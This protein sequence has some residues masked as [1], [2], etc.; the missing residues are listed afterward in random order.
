MRFKLSLLL[1]LCFLT[2]ITNLS[3]IKAV[4]NKPDL[5]ITNLDLNQDGKLEIEV[6]NLGPGS[7]HSQ[8]TA[9]NPPFLYV[10]RNGKAW[11]GVTLGNFDPKKKLKNVGG[12]VKYVFNNL[13]ISDTELVHVIVD[14]NNSIQEINK[15]NNSFQKRLTLTLPDLTV[16]DIFLNNHDRLAIEIT[17]NGSGAVNKMYWEQS[18]VYLYIYRDGKPWGGISLKICD[19]SYKLY[20]PKG[21]ALYISNS[22]RI[23][24]SEQIQV[25]IDPQNMVRETNELNNTL[26]KLLTRASPDLAYF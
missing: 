1:I 24:H 6:S 21:K 18:P 8:S 3:D 23:N 22:I 2:V 26:Q 15:I 9:K 11:G 4:S 17:N 19:P 5:A 10:Y 13:Q 14:P 16:S 12:K 20:H 7:L 25:V